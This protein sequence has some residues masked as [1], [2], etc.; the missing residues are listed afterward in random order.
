MSRVR[1]ADRGMTLI[2]V[3]L[4]LGLFAMLSL[5][6]FSVVHSVLG[7]WQSGERR[8]SGDLAFAATVEQWN[9][10]LGAVHTGPRGWLILDQWQARPAEQDQPA[11]NLP[12]LRFLANGASLPADDPE[13][14]GA[15]EVVWM[16]VPVDAQ[17]SRLTR[18]VRLTQVENRGTSFYDT[19]TADALAKVGAGVPML[20]GVAYLDLQMMSPEGEWVRKYRVPPDTPFDFPLYLDF[21][22][23]RVAVGAQR[24]PTEL[25]NDLSVSQSQLVLRGT[26]PLKVPEYVLIQDEW[27]R[28]TGHFPNL[29]VVEH[30]SRYSS[31]SDHSRGETVWIPVRYQARIHLS[32]GGLRVAL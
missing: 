10:D 17:N 18:L 25:D 9:I 27:L 16:L 23:E 15:V 3:M 19:R 6:V 28:V 29:T 8:G 24:R 1:V 12:R 22:V 20:D 2:E 11:W 4:A 21:A 14:R 32:A 31:I 5:F 7:L 26:V 13:G 30:G